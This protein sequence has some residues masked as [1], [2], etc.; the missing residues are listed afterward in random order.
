[1]KCF[2]QKNKE[3]NYS[4]DEISKVKNGKVNLD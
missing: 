4:K 1:M 2:L 3:F